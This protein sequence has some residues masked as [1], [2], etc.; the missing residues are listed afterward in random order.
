MSKVE[1]LKACRKCGDEKPST[2]FSLDCRTNKT[3]ARC[4]EC[5]S[6]DSRVSQKNNPEF[7][8]NN[9]VYQFSRSKTLEGKKRRKEYRNRP[10]VRVRVNAWM[11]KWQNSP[12]GKAYHTAIRVRDIET[13]RR[14]A[15][16][17]AWSAY[18]AGK[19]VKKPCEFTHVGECLGK[20][21]MDHHKGYT[22]EYWLDVIWL[23][24]R[25]HTLAALWR[26]TIPYFNLDNR[27]NHICDTF[28]RFEPRAKVGG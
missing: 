7:K 28:M 15:R 3:V 18:K 9:R 24:K 13:G 2:A 21:E 22:P 11:R 23:C 19:I 8:E 12:E 14:K 16:I 26:R 27:N 17:M 25:H 10:E 1:T 20:L 6:A 4:K 5:K